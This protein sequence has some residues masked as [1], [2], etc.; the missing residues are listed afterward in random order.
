[1]NRSGF[2]GAPGLSKRRFRHRFCLQCPC[3]L[4]NALAAASSGLQQLDAGTSNR[5]GRMQSAAACLLEATRGVARYLD[6]RGFART[7]LYFER[8]HFLPERK[9]D[10]TLLNWASF[11]S[12]SPLHV[13]KRGKR[14]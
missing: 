9:L 13:Q 2:P 5:E 6:S 7:S 11:Y 1:M 10:K 3:S 4:Q 8:L 12:L 14:W